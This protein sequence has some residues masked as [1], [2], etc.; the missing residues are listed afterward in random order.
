MGFANWIER[1]MHL[2]RQRQ[3]DHV[4]TYRELVAAIAAGTE[5]DAQ[6]VESTLH[7]SG[8]TLADLEAAVRLCEQR[9]LWK[10]QLQQR[11]QLEKERNRLQKDLQAADATLAAAGNTAFPA[12]QPG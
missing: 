10:A 4:K 7:A 8:K 1:I 9:N 6:H 2:Q 12:S 5:P 11:S 3:I